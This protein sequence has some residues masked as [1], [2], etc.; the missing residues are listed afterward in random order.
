VPSGRSFVAQESTNTRQKIILGSTTRAEAS[1]AAQAVFQVPPTTTTLPPT[2][3]TTAP[4][5]T[6]VTGPQQPGSPGFE[7]RKDVEG[8]GG[9]GPFTFSVSCAG[10]TLAPGDAQFTLDVVAG[11]GVPNVHQF[12]SQVPVGTLCTITE[13]STGGASST[14]IRVN[15]GTARVFAAGTVPAVDVTLRNDIVIAV[16]VTN[17]IPAPG[18]PQQAPPTSPGLTGTTLPQ[19][20]PVTGTGES[21][22]YGWPLALGLVVAG[23]GLLVAGRAVR[24]R[25]A[26]AGGRS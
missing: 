5:T 16:R 21:T 9:T 22:S 2:T 8:G 3:A 6:T 7:V 20:L 17:V 19:T 10:A 12:T 1:A 14:Q 18:V 26:R 25:T 11:N 23:A 13:T 24:R 4:P 15:E